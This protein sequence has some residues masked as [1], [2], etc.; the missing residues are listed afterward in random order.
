MKPSKIPV[1][2][3]STDAVGNL[4]WNV[5][6]GNTKE[7][8]PAALAHYGAGVAEV[9]E[10]ML[11]GRGG[12]KREDGVLFMSEVGSPC[13]RQ[14]W[15]KYNDQ[16]AETLM[17]HTLVKFGYGDLIEELIL[18]L[19]EQ[20]GADVADRQRACQVTL[21]VRCEETGEKFIVRGK[22]DAVIDGV[23]V[24]VK[25]A[26]SYAMA[27]FEDPK[28]LQEDDPFGYKDQLTGYAYALDHTEAAF[29]AVDKTLGHMRLSEWTVDEADYEDWERRAGELARTVQQPTP[30]MRP[31]TDVPDGKSGN[32]KLP[33]TCS[34]CAYKTDCWSDANG[35]R[36]LRTFL[37]S[38]GPRFLT[39]VA[40][41]PNVPEA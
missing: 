38:N 40:N 34:Y 15:Y 8:D 18:F 5:A 6:S 22:I 7:V 10:R 28:K 21:P 1:L 31:F 39:H 26:S 4:L 35:G 25:S 2:Q 16:D 32:K 11:R 23:L 27:K 17:P 19:Y 3:E 36:G 33:T 20:A 14:V 13:H 24:D 12:R 41:K 9:A 37:Y 30:P 29:V